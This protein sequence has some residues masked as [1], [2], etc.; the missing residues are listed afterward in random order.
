MEYPKRKNPRLKEYDYSQKGYYFVTICIRNKKKVLC[1][2]VGRDDPG[3]PY[4]ITHLTENGKIVEKYIKLIPQSY[5]NVFVERYVI[6]PDHIHLLILLKNETTDTGSSLKTRR[7]GSSRPTAGGIPQIIGVLK[8]LI[9][10]EVG[11]NIF[12]TSFYDH[13]IRDEG[14]YL[15]HLIYI[16]QN[17]AKWICNNQ[18]A[19]DRKEL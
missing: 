15:A 14:D 19:T 7:A 5:E 16:E 9:N 2:L 4:C 11:E 6:M 3:T 13:I 8:R 17:P 18:K 12:Q 1:N 10:K